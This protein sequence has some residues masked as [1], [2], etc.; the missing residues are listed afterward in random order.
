VN[1][2]FRAYKNA[3]SQIAAEAPNS[4]LLETNGTSGTPLFTTPT[5]IPSSVIINAVQ[6]SVMGQTLFMG[7]TILKNSERITLKYSIS[8]S[9]IS[10]TIK[11]RNLKMQFPEN[12][13]ETMNNANDCSDY[14][15]HK[16]ATLNDGKDNDKPKK[17]ILKN[18]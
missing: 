10:P 15:K 7:S 13:I 5:D 2:T 18:K 16:Q 11:Q 17:G 6:G 1:A 12:I 8:E 4:P 9:A 3:M 14:E